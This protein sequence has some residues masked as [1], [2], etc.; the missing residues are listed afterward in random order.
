MIAAF[1]KELGPTDMAVRGPARD[2]IA[3]QHE[4]NLGHRRIVTLEMQQPAAVEKR[5]AA[6]GPG[7]DLERAGLPGWVGVGTEWNF[8]PEFR[9]F[10]CRLTDRQS[11]LAGQGYLAPPVFSAAK[12]DT[13]PQPTNR[14]DDP[15]HGPAWQGRRWIKH[16][17]RNA[18]LLISRL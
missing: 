9:L 16:R 10:M 11:S 14:V 18:Q 3:R 4:G 15:K 2:F 13:I 5:L 7:G 12:C 6:A 1:K 17:A 8:V